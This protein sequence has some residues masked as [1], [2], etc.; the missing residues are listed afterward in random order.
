LDAKKYSIS[1]SP[2]TS[3][4]RWR[5]EWTFKDVEEEPP[6]MDLI[7]LDEINHF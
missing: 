6:R 7:P 2:F 4:S 1:S 3:Q 5:N